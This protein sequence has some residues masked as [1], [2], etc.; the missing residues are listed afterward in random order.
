MLQ[1]NLQ[2]FCTVY[3]RMYAGY[4]RRLEKTKAEW[5]KVHGQK[6][7]NLGYTE[8][9][10]PK[11]IE[12]DTN[13]YTT[14]EILDVYAPKSPDPPR[15]LSYWEGPGIE[16]EDFRRSLDV[17]RTKPV[18]SPTKIPKPNIGRLNNCFTP[19]EN[20]TLTFQTY[21]LA[22][23][24][25]KRQSEHLAEE[26]ERVE[27]E[28][29]REPMKDWFTIKNSQFSI[30]HARFLELERRKHLKKKMRQKRAQSS[31]DYRRSQNSSRFAQTYS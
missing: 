3:S 4:L 19:Y 1:E 28:W 24:E 26:M 12:V 17:L 5:Y 16:P 20:D 10:K 18:I 21:E 14:T 6:P 31:M 27:D 29:T 8:P 22:R 25:L 30:E 23:R 11:K 13:T 15:K 9:R 2:R 7:P